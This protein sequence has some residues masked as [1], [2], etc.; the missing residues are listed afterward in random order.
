MSRKLEAGNNDGIADLKG[1]RFASISEPAQGARLDVAA[2][3]HITGGGRV[4]ASRK[5]EHAIEFQPEAKIF[6]DTNHELTITDTDDSIWYRTNVV[7]FKVQIPSDEQ[8]PDL[9]MKLAA[10]LSGILWWA[11]AGC[12]E[13][14]KIGLAHPEEAREAEAEYREDQDPLRDFVDECCLLGPDQEEYAKVLWEAYTQWCEDNKV[15]FI[16][17]NQAWS[18]AL[19]SRGCERVRKTIGGRKTRLWVGIGLAVSPGSG[20]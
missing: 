12:L 6:I 3:K 15:R 19:K 4:R 13:W 7:P 18:V 9:E 14:Q 10:E 1:K 5:Y 2:I 16:L 8:D 11:L 20:A 17:S